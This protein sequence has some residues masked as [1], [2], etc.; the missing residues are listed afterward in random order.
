[1]WW[2]ADDHGIPQSR[3]HASSSSRHPAFRPWHSDSSSNCK[4]PRALPARGKVRRGGRERRRPAAEA[5][6]CVAG[7]PGRATTAGGVDEGSCTRWSLKNPW[8]RSHCATRHRAAAGE[9]RSSGP[10]SR[11]PTAR[12]F[13]PMDVAP[14]HAQGAREW[15]PGLKIRR[16]AATQET[17]SNHIPGRTC[18]AYMFAACY[19]ATPKYAGPCCFMDCCPTMAD[20]GLEDDPHSGRTACRWAEHPSSTVVAHIRRMGTT[21]STRT[22]AVRSPKAAREAARLPD[23]PDGCAAFGE[24]S[25]A[26]QYI[27]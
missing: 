21:T 10:R 11:T 19:A 27:D 24:A 7:S 25:G 18:A 6:R 23:V 2:E 5:C 17:F 4:E 20:I 8:P 15:Y 1:M 14:G 13:I 3:H 12:L 22:F 26:R 16:R 9:V